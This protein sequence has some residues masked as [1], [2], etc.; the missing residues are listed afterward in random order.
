MTQYWPR[1]VPKTAVDE[2]VRRLA[3]SRV[4]LRAFRSGQVDWEAFRV[5]YLNEMANEDAK[6]EIRCL[7][8]AARSETITVMCVCKDERMCHRSLLQDM[9]LRIRQEGDLTS[10]R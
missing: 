6:R 10:S 9:I 5:R 7:A 1:G 3:P 8:G 4:L 2:Y